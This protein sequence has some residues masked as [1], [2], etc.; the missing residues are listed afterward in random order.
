MK[1]YAG[2]SPNSR[3]MSVYSHLGR[4][5]L[6]EAIKKTQVNLE[7]SEEQVKKVNNAIRQVLLQEP[8]LVD[9]LI[10][11]IEARG[12]SQ[13]FIDGAQA[14]KNAGYFQEPLT[15]NVQAI[16]IREFEE[17]SNAPAGI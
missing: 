3:M 8:D 1:R 13:L 7:T 2:H 4:D 10:D 6:L 9:L 16:P 11:R 5:A 12:K 14:L 17:I 15:V